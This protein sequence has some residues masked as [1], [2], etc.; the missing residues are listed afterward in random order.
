MQSSLPDIE[1]LI[2]VTLAGFALSLSPGPSML[3][4]LSRSVVQSRLAGVASALGLAAGGVA[5]AVATA[6]G[7]AALLQQFGWLIPLMRLVG[8][9]YLIWLGVGLIRDA[10]A[11]GTTSAA[12]D[13]VD[14]QPFA[15]IVWQGFWIEL[16]NPKTVLFF[17]LFLPPFIDVG[18]AGGGAQDMWLQFLVLGMLVPLTAVPSDLAVAWM[19]GSAK[20]LLVQGGTMNKVLGLLGGATIIAIGFSL[21]VAT[22]WTALL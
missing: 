19:G 10:L 5:L 18:S 17:A 11:R 20:S 2:A 1:A 13:R 12:L 15:S 9:L 21:I 7:L 3:Y 8:S 6:F 4:V 16:L 22:E 14:H